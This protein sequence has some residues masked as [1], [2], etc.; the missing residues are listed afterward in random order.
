MD[1]RSFARVYVEELENLKQGYPIFLPENDIQTGDVGFFRKDVDN[2]PFERLFNVLC[3]ADHP[4]NQQY[5]VPEGFVK[6]Q[7]FRERDSEESGRIYDVLP[8]YYME[9]QEFR[10]VSGTS[11][12]IKLRGATYVLL[13]CDGN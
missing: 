4:I 11:R 1:D 10:R 3:D 5:G 2:E 9:P 13:P 8:D 6:Y 7:T 12:E